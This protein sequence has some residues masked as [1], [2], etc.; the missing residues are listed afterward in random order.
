MAEMFFL[1]EYKTTEIFGEK[2]FEL[3]ITQRFTYY[4]MIALF[5]KLWIPLMLFSV[6]FLATAGGCCLCMLG[7]AKGSESL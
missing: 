7:D 6:G 1:P 3:I 2:L 5:V 4:Q